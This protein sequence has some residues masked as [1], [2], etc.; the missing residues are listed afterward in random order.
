M[1]KKKA[2]KTKAKAKKTVTCGKCK[3]PGHNARTCPTAVAVAEP[4]PKPAPAP[5]PTP[6]VEEEPRRKSTVP[7]RD[8]P[9][10]ARSGSEAPAYR[11]PKCNSVGIIVI[12]RVKDFNESFK[13]E[14]VVYG[15]EVRCE[16]CMNK[17]TPSDL[18][19]KW[20]A[21]PDEKIPVAEI[22]GNA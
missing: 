16:H 19:L 3:E 15:A 17:P 22:P 2:K 11:C 6:R 7:T 12:V 1:A 14:K 5:P 10:A 18:I 4:D 9:T 21:R 8:A 13:Q 20:G